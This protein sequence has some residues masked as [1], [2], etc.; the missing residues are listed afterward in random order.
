AAASGGAQ[1]DAWRKTAKDES[2]KQTKDRKKAT[3]NESDRDRL[4]AESRTHE[5]RHHWLTGA[6]TLFEIGIAMSTVAIITRRRWLSF[7]ATAF[8]VGGI[9]LLGV[10]YVV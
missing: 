2:A 3:E 5:G 10:T 1:A 8:G 9:L 6:A 4:I 7:G